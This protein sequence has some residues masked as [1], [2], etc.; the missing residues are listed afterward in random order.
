MK[1]ILKL[2]LTAFAVFIL[3]HILNGITITSLNT[4]LFVA[5]TLGLLKV[6]IRPLIILL[7]FPITLI[8][9]G[10][11]LFIINTILILITD[12]F[13]DGFYVNGFWSALIFSLLLSGYNQFF[14]LF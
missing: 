7:T 11:F 6:F 13:V 5:I 8:T 10:L 14:I 1:T 2:V 12:Y 3:S 4:A 9:L